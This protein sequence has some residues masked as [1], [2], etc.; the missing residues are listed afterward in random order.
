MGVEMNKDVKKRILD[1]K[2]DALRKRGIE[3]PKDSVENR[4]RMKEAH[5]Y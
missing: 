3:R 5:G 1:K 4:E 2:W